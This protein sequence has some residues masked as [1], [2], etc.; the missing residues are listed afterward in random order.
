MNIEKFKEFFNEIKGKIYWS[1]VAFNYR[2]TKKIISD[3]YIPETDNLLGEKS[4]SRELSRAIL[5]TTFEKRFFSSALPLIKSIR[6]LGIDYPILI[7]INGNLD[8]N[9]DW[10]AR[11][12]FIDEVN[13]LEKV[14]FVT[15]NVMTGMSRNWN[16]GLQL[17]GSKLT[18]C[19]CDDLVISYGFQKELDEAFVKA[20]S[21]GLITLAGFAAFVINENVIADIGWFDERYLGFGEEDGDYVWRF[22]EFYKSLPPRKICL[23]INHENLKSRGD[24]VPGTTKYS[25]TNRVYK[26][27]KYKQ[28]IRGIKGMY[29]SPHIKVLSDLSAHNMEEFRRRCKECFKIVDEKEVNRIIMENL[30]K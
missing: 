7:F 27:I 12:K 16:L 25:L 17:L 15:S 21:E 5:V 29:E 23:A 26:E 28:N 19:L 9:F 6:N 2:V 8:G 13:K 1:L 11:K 24:E 10:T 20:K 14:G 3:K 30:S 4:S 22:Q 18:L